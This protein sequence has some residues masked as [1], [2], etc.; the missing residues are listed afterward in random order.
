MKEEY[1]IA[2][3]NTEADGIVIDRFFGTKEEVKKYLFSLVL[4]DRELDEDMLEDDFSN[5][6]SIDDIEETVAG[7]LNAYN[8][9]ANYH[10][11]YT[12]RLLSSMKIKTMIGDNIYES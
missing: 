7:E 6:S 10:I 12:A 11:D 2:I 4:E 3:C 8:S 5:T 9:F 1:V